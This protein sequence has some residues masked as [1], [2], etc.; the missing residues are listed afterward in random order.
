MALLRRASFWPPYMVY[1]SVI[2]TQTLQITFLHDIDLLWAAFYVLHQHLSFWLV[3]T[4][5][6]L[7]YF[8]FHQR[9][10]CAAPKRWSKYT[11]AE[12]LLEI[13]IRIQIRTIHL[14]KILA[15][16]GIRTWD[17]PGTKPICYQLS[18]PGLDSILGFIK[19]KKIAFKIC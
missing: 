1:I 8:C 10:A 3:G 17:L 18:Y 14:L 9:L 6:W 19:L 12:Y 15:L 4:T 11:I 2:N 5:S 7:L 13:Y 16:A